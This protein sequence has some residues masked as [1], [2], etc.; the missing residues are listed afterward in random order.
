MKYTS[1][2]LLTLQNAGVA[3]ATRYARSRPGPLFA[4]STAVVLAEVIKA[5]VALG[6]LWSQQNFRVRAFGRLLMQQL[7]LD[8]IDNL[9]ILVPALVYVL[10]NNLI[11]FSVSHLN[12]ATFQVSYQLKILTTAVL[13]VLM[14][15]NRRYSRSQWFALLLLFIGIALV[16]WEAQVAHVAHAAHKAEN[17]SHL[18][19]P[20][21]LQF[22]AVPDYFV[23]AQPKLNIP[24]A[25][26]AAAAADSRRPAFAQRRLQAL[27]AET[28]TGA[29]RPPH[30]RRDVAYGPAPAPAP[31]LDTARYGPS[32]AVN[33]EQQH[34]QDPLLGF[35][36][37][38]LA[39]IFSGFAGVYFEKVLKS[40]FTTVYTRTCILK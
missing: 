3:L 28:E 7:V 31:A 26:P 40:M 15:P 11:Y 5:I 34:V 37:V 39:C 24:D 20:Q 16:Q 36:A 10:Q 4:S 19:L 12:A 13:S 6:L 2:V 35:C 29:K 22:K 18:H 25:V 21:R 38:V 27:D 14:L 33:V 9:K 1:L 23:D 8:P 17:H 30:P 32:A